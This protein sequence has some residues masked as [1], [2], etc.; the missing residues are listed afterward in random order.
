MPA[1]LSLVMA[2]QSPDSVDTTTF[3][4]AVHYSHGTGTVDCIAQKTYLPSP[5]ILYR[6]PEDGYF[7]LGRRRA[8]PSSEKSGSSPRRG[9]VSGWRNFIQSSLV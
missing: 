8:H 5:G 9:E 2:L 4:H 6:T 7:F 3:T 1:S